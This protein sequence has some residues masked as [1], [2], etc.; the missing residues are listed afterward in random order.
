MTRARGSQGRAMLIPTNQDGAIVR[1]SNRKTGQPE[2]QMLHGCHP[3][4]TE[5]RAERGGGWGLFEG[6]HKR[7]CRV[8]FWRSLWGAN[9]RRWMMMPA[10]RL[11]VPRGS[12]ADPL[13]L[14]QVMLAKG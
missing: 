14:I 8:N 6:L 5:A 10:R 9:R 11:R 7:G 1:F 13:N 12:G 3:F 2:A 4:V